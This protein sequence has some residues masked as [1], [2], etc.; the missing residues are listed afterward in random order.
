MIEESEIILV[1]RIG[2]AISIGGVGGLE[3]ITEGE[4]TWTATSSST[5]TTGSFDVQAGDIL[6]A[7][8]ISEDNTASGAL[9]ASDSDA[10]GWTQQQDVSNAGRTRL[11]IST[12]VAAGSGSI[13]ATV[14]RTNTSGTISFGI[15][16]LVF[17]NSGGVGTSNKDDNVTGDAS[18]TLTG[19]LANSI[20]V[21]A[22]GDWNAID[23]SSATFNES[24]AGTFIQ[25]AYGGTPGNDYQIYVGYYEDVG[26]A[27]NKTV[28]MLTPDGMAWAIAAVE[29]QA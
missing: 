15:N 14:T 25:T 26:S 27:G 20:I 6:V 8:M 5:K 3:F 12:A 23:G 17:R 7:C 19:V 11:V 29:I 13:T 2:K 21:Q 10:N 9:T 22:I 24:S 18:L 16:V 1:N 4:S 28:G